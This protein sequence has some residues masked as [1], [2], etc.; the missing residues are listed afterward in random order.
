MRRWRLQPSRRN[1]PSLPYHPRPAVCQSCAR[2]ARSITHYHVLHEPQLEQ[3][4]LTALFG[5]TYHRLVAEIRIAVDQPRPLF[6]PQ[7]NRAASQ[8]TDL[9]SSFYVGMKAHPT[10][11]PH[12]RCTEPGLAMAARTKK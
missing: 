2:I 12:R 11:F 5:L 9:G 1:W 7:V 4:V 6:P 10:G 3:I 8:L